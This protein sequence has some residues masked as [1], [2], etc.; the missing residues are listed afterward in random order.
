MEPLLQDRV[1]PEWVDYNSHMNDAAYARVFS[2]AVD[3]LMETLGIDEAFRNQQNYTIFTLE[4]HLCYLHEVHE[5][6]PLQV[7]SQVV[8]HDA[9][10]LHMIFVMKDG[11][12]RRLATSEQMLM[13]MDTHNGRPAPFPR[14]V[15]ERIS[16]LAEPDQGQSIPDEVGRRIGIRKK[17][18]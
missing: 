10:R 14:M 5:D 9:K 16:K 1:R 4:T 17:S 7:E 11:E 12:G 2:M 3:A 18:K 6:A 15:S 8:D 13:G